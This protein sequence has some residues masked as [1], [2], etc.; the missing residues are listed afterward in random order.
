MSS[1]CASF[2]SY[3]RQDYQTILTEENPAGN[4]RSSKDPGIGAAVD[5][6]VLSIDIG[7]VLTAHEGA[8]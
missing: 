8:D 4:I 1:L 7:G 2:V 5:Q 3:F 6:E